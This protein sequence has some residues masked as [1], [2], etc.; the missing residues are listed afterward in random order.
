M[1]TYYAQAGGNWD[2]VSGGT[3]SSVWFDATSG[4]TALDISG[5][6]SGTTYTDTAN[7]YN[8]QG[9]AVNLVVATNVNCTIVVAAITT[10][11]TGTI[12]VGNSGAVTL[13][14]VGNL[15]SV[16][17]S[18]AGAMLTW[19]TGTCSLTINGSMTYTSTSTSGMFTVGTGQTISIQNT[20]GAGTTSI[21]QSTSAGYSILATGSGTYSV[22][23]TGGTALS[24]TTGGRCISS[25][26]TSESC[27]VTGA[28][29][30][31]SYGMS[32][33]HATGAGTL[34]LTGDVTATGTTSAVSWG[35][36]SSTFNFVGKPLGNATNGGNCP[37]TFGGGT[38][39]WTGT[40]AIAANEDVG[41]NQTGGTCYY[42]TG[43]GTKLILNNTN[44]RCFIRKTGGTG[45]TTYLE[46][47]NL[48]SN[49]QS[50]F[51]GH[52]TSSFVVS[53]P[54]IPSAANVRYGVARGF[55]SDSGAAVT[56]LGDVAGAI[57][58]PNSDSPT[59]TQDETS[60]ACVV[61]G[62]KYGS[63]QRPGSAAG[64]GGGGVPVFG[65]N[66]VRRV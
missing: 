2:A 3:T 63:P 9:Q 7:T 33:Y 24:L 5:K 35:A 48:A 60:D 53:G 22:V 38:C 25:V 66:V 10:S 55:P 16:T 32:L 13:G 64:G 18:Y 39:N 36:T 17:S 49:S 52:A 50:M 44:G 59:G 15:T 51:W 61:S 65:G 28:V 12:A 21:T 26:S 57:E 14:A 30:C 34:T 4:G 31:T 20:G 19:G 56:G 6:V 41:F 43:A 29:S 8:L 45:T 23:N 58:M 40:V 42:G 27:V 54:S 37:V 46:M 62:K 47:N 11:S 1:A